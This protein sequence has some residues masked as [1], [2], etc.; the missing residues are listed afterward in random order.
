MPALVGTTSSSDMT[1][2]E[3]SGECRWQ[4]WLSCFCNIC[5]CISHLLQCKCFFFNGVTTMEWYQQS[6][7][8]IVTLPE[9]HPKLTLSTSLISNG[10]QLGCLESVNSHCPLCPVKLSTKFCMMPNSKYNLNVIHKRPILKFVDS[11]VKEAGKEIIF[12][13]KIPRITR[14]NKIFSLGLLLYN[15]ILF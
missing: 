6:D 12:F 15:V 4:D 11:T 10:R 5:W 3:A 2:F 1:G 14:I 9:W 7:I 13:F 8:Y